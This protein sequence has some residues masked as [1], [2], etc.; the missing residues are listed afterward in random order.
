MTKQELINTIYDS[1]K[2]THLEDGIGLYEADCIDDYISADHPDYIRW[3]SYDER[4]NWERLLPLL[5]GAIHSERVNTGSWFFMDAKGKRFLLPCILLLD[6]DNKLKGENPIVTQLTFE[7]IDV[8]GFE[9]LNKDQKQTI[10]NLFDFKIDE[11]TKEN[12]GFDFDNYLKAKEIF[13]KFVI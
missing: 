13:L 5:S 2:N 9:I 10:L 12:N 4:D 6:I 7:P 3:K 1:F 8:A 11:F